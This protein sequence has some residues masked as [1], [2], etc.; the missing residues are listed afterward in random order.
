[1]LV[2]RKAVNISALVLR[3]EQKRLK[4][5]KVASAPTEVHKGKKSSQRAKLRTPFHS[6]PCVRLLR[7]SE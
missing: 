5:D 1:M 3:D 4:D 2:R 6:K 7:A